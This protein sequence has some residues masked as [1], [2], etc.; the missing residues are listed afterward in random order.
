MFQAILNADAVFMKVTYIR[1][2]FRDECFFFFLI[3][4]PYFFSSNITLRLHDLLY[5][6]THDLIL[7]MGISLFFYSQ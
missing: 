3:I 5:K 2:L 1:L 4:R 7:F 6:F